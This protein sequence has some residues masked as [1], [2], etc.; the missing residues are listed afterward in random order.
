MN[1]EQRITYSVAFKGVIELAA[2]G[3]V[4]FETTDYVAEVIELTDAFYE[5]LAVR[6]ELG[7]NVPSTPAVTSTP[8]ASRFSTPT[9][10]PA[11]GSTKAASKGPK[12]PNAA[13]S[14]AQVGFLK[15]LIRE[16]NVPS[17]DAG[18]ELSGVTYEYDGFTM[19]SIQVPIEEL[20]S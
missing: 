9:A 4:A 13:A 15:K 17:D 7:S 20:K 12:D 6:Q 11:T 1:T 5:A 3:K 18:F 14:P 10:S 19:G 8:A 2:A 16:N